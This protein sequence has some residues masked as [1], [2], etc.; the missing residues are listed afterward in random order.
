MNGIHD[1]GGMQ[2]M[3]PVV[4]EKNEPVFHAPWEA[5]VYVIRRA[6]GA[7]RKWTTDSTRHA[8]EL[9]PP[10]EYMRMSYYERWLVSTIDLMIKTGLITRAEVESGNPAPGSVKATP[11]LKAADSSAALVRLT[12]ARPDAGVKAKFKAGERVRARNMHPIGHTRIPRYVRGKLGTI[13]Q[14]H[15]IYVFPDTLVAGL[16]EKPQHV[17]SVRFEARELWGSPASPRHAVYL[18]LWDDYL[19]RI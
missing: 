8:V 13:H 19:E 15:G 16:G 2:D 14:D 1:M 3:G 17:Y 12:V 9:I 10:L 6:M 18:D 5:R 4:Y 7:W 11:P